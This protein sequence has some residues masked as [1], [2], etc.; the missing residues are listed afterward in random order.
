MKLRY[1]LF[2]AGLSWVIY[3]SSMDI[4]QL[5]RETQ[6]EITKEEAAREAQI[7]ADKILLMS[8]DGQEFLI[9]I[10]VAKQSETLKHTIEDVGTKIIPLNNISGKLLKEVVDLLTALYE[11]RNLKGKK[12]LDTLEQKVAIAD[13]FELLR[14][15]NYLDIPDLL[16]LAARKV[17]QQE[18]SKPKATFFAKKESTLREKLV[19][20]AGVSAQDIL[21]I[22][23]KYYFLISGAK[24]KDAPENSAAYSILDWFAYRPELFTFNQH[25]LNLENRNINDLEGIDTIPNIETVTNLYL[26][27]NQITNLPAGLFNL[28]NLELLGLARNQI[29][30]IP[31]EISHLKKLDSLFLSYNK[32]TRLPDSFFDLNKL[33]LLHL[34]RNQITEISNKITQLQKLHVLNLS[35]NLIEQIDPNMFTHMYAPI[36]SLEY[37]WLANN[38]LTKQNK[39]ALRANWYV[40]P[41]RLSSTLYL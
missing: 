35:N 8:S 32:I 22:V 20:I 12:L 33:Q 5:Y 26:N 10:E 39:D 40:Y 24:L 16:N 31:E 27:D 25:N 30:Q 7:P 11:N 29:T 15:A 14:A 2:I 36:G 1:I 19:Q 28:T 4:S 34:N 23:A 13:A 18:A 37:L 21:K 17:A 41:Y 38:R 3:A 6:E 9:P